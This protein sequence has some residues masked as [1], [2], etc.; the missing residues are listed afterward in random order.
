MASA[1]EQCVLVSNTDTRLTGA[2]LVSFFFFI[3]QTYIQP[4]I[5]SN[6]SME[7]LLFLVDNLWNLLINDGE[8]RMPLKVFAINVAIGYRYA[9]PKGKIVYFGIDMHTR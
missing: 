1:E 5:T 3:N 2:Y 6:S 9:L 8:I 4:G 7:S